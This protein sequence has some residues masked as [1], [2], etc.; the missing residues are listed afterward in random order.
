MVT[1]SWDGSQSRPGFLES[2]AQGERSVSLDGSCL[3]RGDRG[4]ASASAIASR[5]LVSVPMGCESDRRGDGRGGAGCQRR[6]GGRAR[7]LG[8]EG[9]SGPRVWSVVSR[10]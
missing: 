3:R 1:T 6:Q 9:E 7:V 5:L 10:L 2:W 8:R 4:E